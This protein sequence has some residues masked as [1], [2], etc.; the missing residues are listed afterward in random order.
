MLA[1]S[2]SCSSSSSSTTKP[3]TTLFVVGK[4]KRG[5]KK[6]EG[7]SRQKQKPN[8]RRYGKKKRHHLRIKRQPWDALLLPHAP[9]N[10]CHEETLGRNW[11]LPRTAL[12][13]LL[14]ALFFCPLEGMFHP[15]WSLS[16]LPRVPFSDSQEPSQSFQESLHPLES[17]S[18]LPKALPAH[19]PPRLFPTLSPESFRTLVSTVFSLRVEGLS[20]PRESLLLS[21][22][23]FESLSFSSSR[24]YHVRYTVL[25]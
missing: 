9:P 2:R 24:G 6:N 4:K 3:A 5:P 8:S 15:L 1:E 22:H 10:R 17:V 18:T 25:L 12:V 23:L 7:K 21:S 13:S 11:H 16:I 14:G 19:S 20:T